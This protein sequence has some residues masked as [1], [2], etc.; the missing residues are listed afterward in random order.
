MVIH[1]SSHF[2]TQ[3]F[4]AASS[5][6]LPLL[7]PPNSSNAYGSG[8]FVSTGC[9]VQGPFL[10]IQ[11]CVCE[12][13]VIGPYRVRCSGSFMSPGST[14]VDFLDLLI[15]FCEIHD[16]LACH[17][18]TALQASAPDSCSHYFWDFIFRLPLSPRVLGCSL[19]LSSF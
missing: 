18:I 12:L 17:C 15:A 4:T 6:T 19:S 16:H 5:G 11:K 1:F 14:C 8:Y 9:D 2:L 7:L 3:P 10:P 13:R